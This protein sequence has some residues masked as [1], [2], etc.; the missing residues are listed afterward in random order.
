VHGTWSHGDV[1]DVSSASAPLRAVLFLRQDTRNEIVP[2]TDC[3]QIWKRL[4]ATLIKP[5]V[6]AEWWQKELDVLERLVNEVPC[7]TMDFDKSGA[8]VAELERLFQIPPAPSF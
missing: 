2:L 6:T 1:A 5:M 8:I 4:L 7:Y 3:K